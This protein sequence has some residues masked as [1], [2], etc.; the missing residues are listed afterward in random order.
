MKKIYALAA[1]ACMALAANA[2]NGA[3]L[4]I[5]GQ[6][7]G[8][9]NGGFANDWNVGDKGDPTQMTF[10]DG[11]YKIHVNGLSSFTI[12]TVAD[13]TWD[14]WQAEGNCYTCEYGDN[15]GATVDLKFGKENILTPWQGDYDVVVSG[16][17]KT[18]TLTTNTPQPP[19]RVFLRGDMNGWLNEGI[20]GE[21]GEAWLLTP[22][23]QNQLFH[24]VCGD[25]QVIAAGET[26]KIADAG[27]AKYNYGSDG[28]PIL[29]DVETDIFFNAQANIALEE[30]W[31]GAMWA[32]ITKDKST[33]QVVFSN[34]KELACPE[35][36]LEI[37]ESGVAA[38]EAEENAAPVYY[39]MQGVRVA[40]PEN[41]LYIVVKGDKASK[42]LVK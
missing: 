11:V 33:V 19:V 30:E 16:D 23:H 38:I 18:I 29:F 36:W 21:L 8:P 35:A 15:P 20:D 28:E 10:E 14:N 1:V 40:Q 6:S 27:W 31:N 25:D 3:P 32:I 12:S 42:V 22:S 37:L 17:L 24:M 26:F 34:D 2:Q 13:G 4:Y 5:T 39:N 9:D 7:A 41:G